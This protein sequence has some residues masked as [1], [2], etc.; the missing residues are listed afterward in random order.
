LRSYV[1]GVRIDGSAQRKSL[2]IELRLGDLTEAS[3]TT[4]TE[5][6]P[7]SVSW[8]KNESQWSFT[9]DTSKLSAGVSIH[10]RLPVGQ[11]GS[12]ANLDGSK[13]EAG[14][15]NVKHQGRWLDVPLDAKAYRG[16]FG[17]TPQKHP[18]T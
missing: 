11:E 2:L 14:A 18:N 5:F 7:V 15:K 16:F 13:L 8:K 10:L 12:S 4:E 1:L 17:I 9:I 3:G 6:G